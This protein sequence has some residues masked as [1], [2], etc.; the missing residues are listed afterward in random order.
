M[1]S[2]P[3]K[4]FS[5]VKLTPITPSPAL[6]NQREEYP[7]TSH[8]RH[9]SE[10]GS[11]HLHGAKEN[12]R[13]VDREALRN[14]LNHLH[15]TERHILALMH[16]AKLKENII[17]RAIPEPCYDGMITCLWDDKTVD[18]L[19]LE[20]FELLHLLIED[21][22]SMIPL[23]A[24]L[25]KMDARGIAIEMPEKCWALG[26][27]QT[28]RYRC[29]EILVEI[30]KK[31]FT[32]TGELLDF[33]SSGFR[34]KL[35]TERYSPFKV[36]CGLGFYNVRLRDSRQVLFSGKCRCL[37]QGEGPS[38]KDIVFA[39]PHENLSSVKENHV[40]N[41]RQKLVPSPSLS[42]EHPL[43][44]KK[45]HLEISDI[46]NSGFSVYEETVN[47]LLIK[48]L[49]IPNG[50]ISFAGMFSLK[51]DAEV[52]YRRREEGQGI[53]CGLTIRDMSIQDYS[54]LTHILGN[55]MDP[56]AHV[57]SDIDMDALWDF[58][59]DTSFIYPQKYHFLHARRDKFKETYRTL[60][61]KKPEIAKNFVY[62]RNG[63]ILGHMSMVR[64]YER[65]WMIQHHAALTNESKRAGFMVLK[66]V[67]SF[68]H[69]LYRLPSAMT[70]YIMCYFQPE[71]KFPDRVF[72]GYARELKDP[73]RCSMDLFSYFLYPGA[74]DSSII[75]RGWSLQEC[76]RQDVL[77][78][79]RFYEKHS[80]GLILDTIGLTHS[81]ES[82][83]EFKGLYDRL[84]LMRRWKAYALKRDSKLAAVIVLEKS[85]PGLNLSELLNG[86][87]I[88]V[89]DRQNLPWQILS[90]VL[91]QFAGIYDSEHIPVLLYPHEYTAEENIDLD[92]KAY[93]Q[94]IYDARLVESFIAYLK[95]RFRVDY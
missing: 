15:F 67:M 93:V 27:R 73:K 62:Q 70:D 68:M 58:L 42:F 84:G 14:T 12:A 37:R 89:L 81:G 23:S 92:R 17:L 31:G 10:Y 2:G 87:K 80:G 4:L 19:S 39:L 47:G 69:N 50:K 60:Y 51:C 34:V 57:D 38:G 40:R 3:A 65:A 85:D 20:E 64:A 88:F 35:G 29:R 22:H 8:Q 46:S 66:Q 43:L 30:E 74:S 5:E 82:S 45:C 52:V 11:F 95:R 48:G 18:R 72:A 55:A 6:P 61:C 91:R 13:L 24:P 76:S 32:A 79:N 90:N 59:F 28:K 53:R 7:A 56:Q 36:S 26:R 94:W 1:I 54:R 44:R 86:I 63:R 77:A 78:L 75:P 83:Q 71:S 25:I 16:H 41:P 49:R 9:H 33:S 21:G